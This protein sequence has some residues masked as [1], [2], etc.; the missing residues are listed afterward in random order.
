VLPRRWLEEARQ[1]ERRVELDDAV[2]VVVRRRFLPRWRIGV[3]RAREHVPRRIDG[4]AAG[5]PDRAA[6]GRRRGDRHLPVRR[7]GTALRD[8]DDGSLVVRTVA[9]VAAVAEHDVRPAQVER[10]A[11]QDRLRIG[12]RR[13]DDRA[14]DLFAV[15]DAKALEHVLGLAGV[16]RIRDRVQHARGRIDHRRA[17][18]PDRR[19]DVAARQRRRGH[20]RAGARVPRD[21]ARRRFERVDVIADGRDVDARA[22]DERLA[23]D[24]LAEVRRLPRKARRLRAD[25]LRVVARPRRVAVVRRPPGF[26]AARAR[27]GC[28]D[29]KRRRGHDYGQA[30]PA[31]VATRRHGG[32]RFPQR[33]ERRPAR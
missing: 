23:P 4:R 5:R 24:R 3:A 9:V 28:H 33:H 21:L 10:R 20:R 7:R 30:E 18:D 19:R 13:V 22:D 14:E 31:Q 29:Q 11:L 2:R 1:A 16:P 12:A 26:A 15:A 25:R 8:G 32:R 17:D 27:G 6:G